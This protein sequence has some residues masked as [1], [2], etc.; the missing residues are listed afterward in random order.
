MSDPSTVEGVTLADVRLAQDYM[1]GVAPLADE[2]KAKMTFADL[3][4]REREVVAWEM[5][6]SS[7]YNLEATMRMIAMKAMENPP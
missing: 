2:A 1:P 3:R 7:L 6:S 4:L 5:I